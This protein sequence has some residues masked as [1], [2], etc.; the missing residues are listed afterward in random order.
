MLFWLIVNCQ[1]NY[2]H[3]TCQLSSGPNGVT[4]TW[5]HLEHHEGDFRQR[6]G[7]DIVQKG[8][9]TGLCDRLDLINHLRNETQ[10]VGDVVVCVCEQLDGALLDGK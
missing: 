8:N 2:S 6:S 4:G 3:K 7:R 10:I 5:I 9:E 1:N